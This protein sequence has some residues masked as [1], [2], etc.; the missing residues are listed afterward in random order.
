MNMEG[1]IIKT[2][3]FKKDV[4]NKTLTVYT[5]I[6]EDETLSARAAMNHLKRVKDKYPMYDVQFV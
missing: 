4:D 5:S 2:D 6:Y 3:Q 1:D